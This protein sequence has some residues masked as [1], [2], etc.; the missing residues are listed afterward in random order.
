MER[1]VSPFLDSPRD[2]ATQTSRRKLG[3][4]EDFVCQPKKLL[5]LPSHDF[6]LIRGRNRSTVGSVAQQ[7]A[8]ESDCGDDQRCG[9]WKPQSQQVGVANDLHLERTSECNHLTIV[10]STPDASGHVV[11]RVHGRNP[12]TRS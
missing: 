10:S 12:A 4:V 9:E 7:Y 6:S 1:S 3:R 2:A 8:D 11:S 5:S